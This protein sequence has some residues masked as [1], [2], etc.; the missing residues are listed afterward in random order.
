M[1]REKTFGEKLA[2]GLIE[3]TLKLALV[4]IVFWFCLTV[5][6]EVLYAMF[7]DTLRETT[8]P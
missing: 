4:V 8:A 5:L 3:A 1:R 2:G 7:M 6:P